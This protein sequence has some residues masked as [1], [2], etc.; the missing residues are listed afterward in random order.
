[1]HLVAGL[2]GE[3]RG[4]EGVGVRVVVV[5]FCAEGVPWVGEEGNS[6]GS[7]FLLVTLWMRTRWWRGIR[8][9][10]LSPNGSPQ[11]TALSW[12]LAE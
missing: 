9:R 12:R 10:G 8:W 5:G 7:T 6:I 3:G 11:P 2:A 1:M 4:V